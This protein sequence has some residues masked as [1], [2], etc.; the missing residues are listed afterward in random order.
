MKPLRI[1]YHH[2]TQGRG[3]E[4]LH[5]VHIVRALESLG[6]EVDILSPPGIDPLADIGA[7]PVDKASVDT[8]GMQSVWKWVSRHLPN[9]LFELVEIIYNVPASRRLESALKKKKYDLVYERYAF[10]LV[11]GAIKA[12]KYNIPFVLEANEVSGIENRARRQS[13]PRVCAFF[14]RILLKRTTAVMTVSSTL[15]D[16]LIRQGSPEDTVYVV[17]NAIDVDK[18]HVSGDVS[19]LRN[20]YGIGSSTVVGF[21]GWFDE[22][23]RLDMLVSLVGKLRKKGVD[24]K[25]LLIGDGAVLTEI[26]RRVKVEKLEDAFIFTGPVKRQEIHD[27]LSLLDIAVISHSN[28]FGSPVVMFE[29]MA[30]KIPIVAAAVPPICDV[31]TNAETGCLFE[32]LN[33]AAYEQC[34]AALLENP[35]KAKLLAENA[36]RLVASKNTWKN[37]ART[38]I[39][40]IG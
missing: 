27:Y 13:F 16:M 5:I 3:A 34:L 2:R 12:G 28:N 18:I 9:W 33:E 26:R 15:R 7:P 22:W 25:A 10:F 1:L 17:P 23:D 6:H 36:F 29:F 30:L 19:Q 14:E 32:P 40:A 21:A 11:A 31:L 37:N 8:Q 4:G 38:I 39:E 24:V 35:D 20:R